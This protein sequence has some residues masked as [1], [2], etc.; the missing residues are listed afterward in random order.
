MATHPAAPARY[1]RNLDNRRY[2]RA[3]LEQDL[4]GAW[5]LRRVWGSLDSRLGGMRCETVAS[6]DAG[7]D[8]LARIARRRQQHGYEVH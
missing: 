6:Y 2:Y 5:V 7:L 4:F 1:W 3:Y 8:A